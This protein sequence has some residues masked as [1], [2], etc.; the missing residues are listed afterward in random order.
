MAEGV[1][2]NPPHFGFI[3]DDAATSY[4]VAGDATASRG[5]GK[6]DVGQHRGESFGG[7]ER[8][9]VDE[10]DERP[11]CGILNKVPQLLHA[12][13]VSS[14]KLASSPTVL[15]LTSSS[16]SKSMPKACCTS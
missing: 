12:L 2:R 7:P 1:F 10:G 16:A 3:R 14:R 13:S 4:V 15:M 8:E 6:I 11:E 5:G 9:R